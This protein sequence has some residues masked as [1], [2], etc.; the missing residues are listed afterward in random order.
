MTPWTLDRIDK[1]LRASWAADTCSPDEAVPEP[2][3]TGARVVERQLGGP[4]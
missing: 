3:V 4:A 1:A 2:R